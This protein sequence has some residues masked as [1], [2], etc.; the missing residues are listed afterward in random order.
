[1]CPGAGLSVFRAVMCPY[2][3]ALLFC[4]AASPPKAT[5]LDT[6]GESEPARVWAQ[7]WHS[8]TY[9]STETRRKGGVSQDL[10]VLLEQYLIALY[11]F[12]RLSQTH[13]GALRSRP[14]TNLHI[15]DIILLKASSNHFP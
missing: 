5:G 6:L 9:L 1:M 11:S 8:E 7:I 4:R 3:S 10:Q 13:L 12:W 15:T 14:A 2:R